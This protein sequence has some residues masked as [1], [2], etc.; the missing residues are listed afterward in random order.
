MPSRLDIENSIK[1]L[2]ARYNAEYALLFGSYARR[3]ETPDTNVDG[4][5]YGGKNFKKS[6]IFVFAE[7][8]REMLGVNVDTFEMCEVN[9]GT[10]F[11]E[12][13]SYT[14]FSLI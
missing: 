8:I 13:F 2:I 14:G 5:V 11:Y 6:N 9:E 12:N 3:E 10:P 4:V 7:D 1:N